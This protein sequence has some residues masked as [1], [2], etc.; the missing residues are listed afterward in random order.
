M[1]KPRIVYILRHGPGKWV[2]VSID[3]CEEDEKYQTNIDVDMHRANRTHVAFS[4]KVSLAEDFDYTVSI[5]IDICKYVDGGCKTYQTL[6]DESAINFCEKYAKQNVDA[7]LQM[8]DMNG[9]PLP[10]GDYA[11]DDYIFNVAELPENAVYG[12]FVG[13]GYLIKQGVEFSCVKVAANFVKND[14]EDEED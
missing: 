9:F 6:A 13:K 8:L 7:A 4:F 1:N 3:R 10:V 14:D 2:I 12:D 11:V 5:R